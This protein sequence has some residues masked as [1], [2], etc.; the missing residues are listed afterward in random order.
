MDIAQL[1]M[2]MSQN[3][4]LNAVSTSMLSKSIDLASSQ[5]DMMTKSMDASSPSLESL[6]YSTSG[7]Q[8]DMR[9]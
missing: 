5:V 2:N 7:T 8:I 9:V 3:Q 4:I 6:V 1:S